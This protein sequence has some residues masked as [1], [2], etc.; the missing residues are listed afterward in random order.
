M[1]T[2]SAEQRT[3]SR[4][5]IATGNGRMF[6]PERRV[7]SALFQWIAE[8]GGSSGFAGRGGRARALPSKIAAERIARRARLLRAATGPRARTSA[9]ALAHRIGLVSLFVELLLQCDARRLV[10]RARELREEAVDL[11]L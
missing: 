7:R 9:E 5:S 4:G 6:G 11:R 2:V 3:S 1:V 10:L 8:R